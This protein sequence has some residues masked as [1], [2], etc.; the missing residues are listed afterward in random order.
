MILENRD[1]G[2]KQFIVY[3]S[4]NEVILI[5]ANLKIAQYYDKFLDGKCNPINVYTV[6]DGK[7]VADNQGPIV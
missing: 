6:K 2:N 3:N 5:T 7:T 4:C 1:S